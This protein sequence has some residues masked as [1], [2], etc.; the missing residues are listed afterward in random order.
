MYKA[1]F[2][3]D[4]HART[5]WAMFLMTIPPFQIPQINLC[6]WKHLITL[7][8]IS[9]LK[10]ASFIV[11][12]CNTC[13]TKQE[14]SFT[15]T[16]PTTH[17]SLTLNW[18]CKR[19]GIVNLIAFNCSQVQS[20]TLRFSEGNSQLIV[21]VTVRL[22]RFLPQFITEEISSLLRCEKS[23]AELERG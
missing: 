3:M 20:S 5:E 22:L 16:W 21:E 18:K 1:L 8:S 17:P 4:A 12:T 23:I 13:N 14:N 2:L 15:V 9:N 10:Q 6:Y 19:S 7:C 11:H